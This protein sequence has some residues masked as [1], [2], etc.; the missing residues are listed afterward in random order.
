[1]TR[2]SIHTIDKKGNAVII[3]FLLITTIRQMD[4]DRRSN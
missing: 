2:R 4:G 1:M 3:D